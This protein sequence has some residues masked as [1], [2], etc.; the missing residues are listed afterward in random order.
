MSKNLNT[1]SKKMQ[2]QNSSMLEYLVTMHI[3][4]VDKKGKIKG[5][6]F[7]KKFNSADLLKNRR[8]AIEY[9]ID[10]RNFFRNNSGIFFSSPFE[11]K[12][13]DY[14][15]YKSFSITLQVSDNNGTYIYIDEPD[16]IF[17]FL[18]LESQVFQNYLLTPLIKVDD[19]HGHPHSVLEEDFSFFYFLLMESI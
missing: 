1:K 14:K 10:Q 4:I 8:E 7:D 3:N 2:L 5:Q 18:D 15:N 11:A 19:F 16:S 12:L 9:Y 17:E 6:S 13:T